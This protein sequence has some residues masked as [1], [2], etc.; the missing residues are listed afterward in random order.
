MSDDASNWNEPYQEYVS[1]GLFKM[2]PV[3]KQINGQPKIVYKPYCSGKGIALIDR[4]I[5]AQLNGSEQ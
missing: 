4:L 2:M 1:A 3:E 5:K